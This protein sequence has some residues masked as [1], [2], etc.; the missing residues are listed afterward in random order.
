MK[1]FTRAEEQILWV[2]AVL[3]FAIPNGLFL[4]SLLTDP[5]GLREAMANPIA[6]AF[7]IEAGLLLILFSWLITR[8]GG[9]PGWPGFVLLSLV[10]SLACSVP[11]YLALAGRRGRTKPPSG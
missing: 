9:R 7:M 2:G 10:G 5:S 6:Q 3:G 4:F 11:A 8:Q 1:P